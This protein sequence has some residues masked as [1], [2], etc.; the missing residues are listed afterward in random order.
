MSW[1]R[2]SFA[3]ITLNAV[4]ALSSCGNAVKCLSPSAKLPWHYGNDFLALVTHTSFLRANGD[5]S[6]ELIPFWYVLLLN[7]AVIV[8]GFLLAKRPGVNQ[9]KRIEN[10]KILI[11]NTPMDTDKI[12]VS[13]QVAASW[14]W[15][16][17][18]TA[19]SDWDYVR[20][21]R[22]KV[23]RNDINVLQPDKHSCAIVSA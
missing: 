12:K 4:A 15:L 1:C 10:A 22:A 13:K 17:Q 8:L 5:F 14:G 23:I 20:N 11:A 2:S 19:G 9:P 16:L 18:M 6:F 7:H 3:H 21:A